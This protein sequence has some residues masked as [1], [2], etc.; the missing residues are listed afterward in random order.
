M[1]LILI[2]EPP[3]G[4]ENQMD[5]PTEAVIRHLQMTFTP[6]EYR[7]VTQ[8]PQYQS[9]NAFS[10]RKAGEEYWGRLPSYLVARCPICGGAYTESLD[11][12]SLVG[13][14]PHPD[15]WDFVYTSRRKRLDDTEE[16]KRLEQII[17]GTAQPDQFWAATFE[18]TP[19]RVDCSHFVAVQY[20]I[21]LHGVL[22]KEV[23]YFSN[24][25]EVPFVMPVFLPED[26]ESY[27]VMHSLPICRIEKERFVPRYSLY[28][29]T[30]YSAKPQKL[31]ERR[32]AEFTRGDPFHFP[33]MY[34]WRT[35]QLGNLAEAW[36]L[37][38]WVAKGKLLW[39]DL[40]HPN[41]PLKT[42]PVEDFPYGN[43]EGI[44]RSY[45]YRKGELK[46]DP[47]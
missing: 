34:T 30:Y 42:G 29:L 39:L 2:R 17:E 20:F 19:Q 10:H 40:D 31:W 7:S 41:L 4:K 12:H 23:Q 9:A 33:K 44:R 45:T 14:H 5:Q 3:A 36:D 21:N 24:Q 46:V 13:W 15:R 18:A 8:K 37:P 35:I 6:A 1:L 32:R 43:I 26:I 25:S 11:T 47:Y 16:Q 22:P 38:S 27:A 28:L